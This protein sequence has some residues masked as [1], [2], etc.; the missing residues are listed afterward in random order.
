V[1]KTESARLRSLALPLLVLACGGDAARSRSGDRSDAG[2]VAPG[3]GRAC[4][5]ICE[6]GAVRCSGT[7]LQRCQ[8]ESDA[9]LECGVGSWVL[10]EDCGAVENCDYQ[11]GACQIRPTP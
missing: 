10:I 8:A 7:I 2:L 5:S 9:G 4:L 6:L 11:A 1:G 3:T